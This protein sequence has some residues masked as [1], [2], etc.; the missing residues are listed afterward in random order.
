MKKLFLYSLLF[1]LFYN[2][3]LAQ[4]PLPEC[5]GNDENI[6]KFSIKHFRKMQKWT[7]CHG[8]AIGPGKT[9][10]VGEFYE[11]KFHGHGTYTKSGRQYIGEWQKGKKH[12][13]GKYSYANG[14]TYDGE[15]IKNK[16]GK[17]GTYTYS[18]GDIYIGEW[19][20]IKYHVPDNQRERS[21]VGTYTHTNGD[22][23]TGEW[24]QGL[25]HGK[26]TFIYSNGKIEKGL[27]KKN[28][29]IKEN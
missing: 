8:T 24:K 20:K 15:W 9:K 3:S 16:Y 25:R 14:D 2:I 13:K 21:G 1:I 17:D 22:K 4:S 23:Y 29:L 18:N 7:N 10:Y 28:K 5:E 11:G 12:G 6:S 26:G 19:K 27:W